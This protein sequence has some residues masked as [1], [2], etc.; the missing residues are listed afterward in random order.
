MSLISLPKIMFCWVYSHDYQFCLNALKIQCPVFFV[1]LWLVSS[2][3]NLFEK[4]YFFLQELLEWS[5]IFFVL[6]LY[7]Y[8]KLFALAFFHFIWDLFH[9]RIFGL[10]TFII[11][12]KKILL[13][14]CLCYLCFLS[15]IFE[16]SIICFNHF[17][18]FLNIWSPRVTLHIT[19]AKF[20]CLLN[21]CSVC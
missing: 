7:H 12:E 1:V 19:L 2:N 21:F 17:S 16:S 15:N 3:Y 9:F 18:P 5:L 11:S 10:V 13:F 4:D 20:S 8:M 6:K 14:K